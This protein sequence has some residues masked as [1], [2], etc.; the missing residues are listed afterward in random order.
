MNKKDIDNYIKDSSYKWETAKGVL[1]KCDKW[2]ADIGKYWFEIIH[3]DITTIWVEDT[4]THKVLYR[5]KLIK[6]IAELDNIIN[7]LVV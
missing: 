2:G 7:S 4:I 6:S 5:T 1:C 3:T